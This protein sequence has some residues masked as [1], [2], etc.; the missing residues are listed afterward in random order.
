MA[1]PPIR[2][3][4]KTKASASVILGWGRRHMFPWKGYWAIKQGTPDGPVAWRHEVDVGL[5]KMKFNSLFR[6]FGRAVKD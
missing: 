5:E 4:K 3:T 2:I 6:S 1:E